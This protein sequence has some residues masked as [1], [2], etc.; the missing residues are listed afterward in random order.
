MRL[1][2]EIIT[3]PFLAQIRRTASV[4]LYSKGYSQQEIADL[5]QVSQAI[6]SNYLNK[7]GKVFSEVPEL[8]LENAHNIGIQVADTL[9]SQG[10]EGVPQ[11]VSL[12]CN[13]CK[14]LRQGGATCSYHKMLNPHLEESCTR[15][16]T[17][18]SLITIQLNRENIITNLQNIYHE[19]IK[20]TKHNYLIPEIG[21]Q[22]V[23]GTAEMSNPDDIAGFPG[24]IIKRK[25]G[26]PSSEFPM[27][28]ASETLS[29]LLLSMKNH[30]AN[31]RGIAGVKTSEW[32]VEKLDSSNIAYFR[33]QGFDKN[34]SDGIDL[35]VNKLG[36]KKPTYPFLIVDEGSIGYEAISYIFARNPEELTKVFDKLLI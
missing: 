26:L 15:C 2:C 25:T 19:L 5:L 27:F 16:N 9:F 36:P 10:N 13:S 3:E 22:I 11:A 20:T 4:N 12:V 14:K 6:V 28:G 35:V 34:F 17:S 7:S 18:E 8:I 33:I 31:L 23:I 21:L 30:F 1:P 24:R 29:E 32:L